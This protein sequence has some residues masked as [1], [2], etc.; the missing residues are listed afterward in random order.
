MWQQQQ[1]QPLLL[2]PPPQQQQRGQKHQQRQTPGDY[3][4]LSNANYNPSHGNSNDPMYDNQYTNNN[5][6][7][8]NS[9]QSLLLELDES[10]ICEMALAHQVQNLSSPISS[11][12]GKAEY[13]S[14][15]IPLLTF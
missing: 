3:F 15:R 8:P 13:L 2:P 9:Y 5:T 4:Y 14:G 6:D 12:T 11:L 1:Q 10:T 7:N